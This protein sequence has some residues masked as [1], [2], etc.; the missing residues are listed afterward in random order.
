MTEYEVTFQRKVKNRQSFYPYGYT[1]VDTDYTGRWKIV[2]ANGVSDLY[3][4][5]FEIVWEDYPDPLWELEKRKQNFLGWEWEIDTWG[6]KSHGRWK[7]RVDWIHEDDLYVS[8]IG[9]DEFINVCTTC[10][11]QL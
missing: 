7:A 8:V 1:W 4:E 6:A 9:R 5:C 10:E 11:G 2:N 3:I